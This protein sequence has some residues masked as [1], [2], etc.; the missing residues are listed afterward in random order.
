MKKP[1]TGI[2]IIVAQ[3]TIGL[4]LEKSPGVPTH[5]IIARVLVLRAT[6]FIN[7]S[8]TRGQRQI[9]E[10]VAMNETYYR[11]NGGLEAKVFSHSPLYRFVY[12][13]NKPLTTYLDGHRIPRTEKLNAV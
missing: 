1:T 10:T 6:R 13:K 2:N 11:G 7:S 3:F 4:P 9:V 8:A 5:F 12:D